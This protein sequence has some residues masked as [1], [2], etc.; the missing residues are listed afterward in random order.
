MSNPADGGLRITEVAEQTGL[1]AHALRYY[2][3]DALMLE[4]VPR[5]AAGH[6]RYSP[7]DVQWIIFITKLRSTGMPMRDIRMYA[8]LVR[9]GDQSEPQ[10]LALLIAHRARVRRQLAEVTDHL[11]AIEHKIALYRSLRRPRILTSSA[12]YLVDSTHATHP[13]H[14]R[15]NLAT[16]GLCPRTRLYGHV[17][18]LRDCRRSRSRADHPPCPRPGCQLSRHR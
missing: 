6:R 14:P 8:E 5:S 2:E 9:R 15:H 4:S 12:L 11:R 18:V 16:H 17:R 7:G 13:T 10:R 3:R 1:T